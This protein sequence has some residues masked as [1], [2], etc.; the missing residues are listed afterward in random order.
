MGSV[1]NKTKSGRPKSATSEENALNMLL[2]VQEDPHT[3]TR[4]LARDYSVSQASVCNL[5]K[6]V[7]WQPYKIGYNYYK[8]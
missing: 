1:K 8:N 5:M 6:S 3:S 2:S 4:Q 7:K